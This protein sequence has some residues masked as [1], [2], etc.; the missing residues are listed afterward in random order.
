MEMCSNQTV[1]NNNNDRFSVHVDICEM[2]VDTTV[3]HAL[4]LT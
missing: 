1:T 3:G 4:L 2:H